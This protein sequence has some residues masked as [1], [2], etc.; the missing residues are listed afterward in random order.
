VEQL[1]NQLLANL[2]KQ[3]QRDQRA[4]TTYN[5]SQTVPQALDL[6][7]LRFKVLETNTVS[8]RAWRLAHV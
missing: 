1:S 7:P 3:Q 2:V 4:L 6:T 5:L 8:T